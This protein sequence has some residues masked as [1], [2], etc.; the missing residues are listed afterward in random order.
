MCLLGTEIFQIYMQNAVAELYHRQGESLLTCK[1]ALQV[2]DTSTYCCD[3]TD[4][5][6]LDSTWYLGPIR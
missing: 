3:R 4:S 5:L 1:D 2:L 6:W